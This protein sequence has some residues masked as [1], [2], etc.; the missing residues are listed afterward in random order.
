MQDSSDV[1]LF[2][3]L[4]GNLSDSNAPEKKAVVKNLRLVQT[5]F[6]GGEGCVGGIAGKA[7]SAEIL[8]SRSSS[9]GTINSRKITGGL[10]GCA[11]DVKISESSN[12]AYV[13]TSSR[14]TVNSASGGLVGFNSGSLSI[15]NSYNSGSVRGNVVGGFVG[16]SV[17]KINIVNSINLYAVSGTSE[18]TPIRTRLRFAF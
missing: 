1:G 11:S 15:V 7:E 2:A 9:F 3:E 13:S 14:D 8:N 17:G 5:Y 10:I 6:W 4:R 16:S 18:S 12:H